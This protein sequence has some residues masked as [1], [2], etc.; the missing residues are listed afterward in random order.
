MNIVNPAAKTLRFIPEIAKRSSPVVLAMACSLSAANAVITVA[1]FDRGDTTAAQVQSTFTGIGVAAPFPAN[2]PAYQG[3]QTAV[4]GT[5][6]LLLA[7][8]TTLAAATTKDGN[9]DFNSIGNLVVR[10]R[11]TPS[12]DSG[13][14]TYSDVYRDFITANFQGIELSGLT[15]DFNYDVTFYAYDNSG[16]RTQTFTD[17]T[18]GS[19]GL[20]GSVTYASGSTF[21]SSTPNNIF[22]T[23][24]NAK[25]DPQGRLF[26]TESGVGTAGSSSVA[27]FNAVVVSVPEPS[28]SIIVIGALGMLGFRRRRCL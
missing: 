25:S 1:S 16:N 18:P 11:G 3:P 15:A 5:V 8:N 7:A 13:T 27:L 4:S 28:S 2:P 6:T 26:F 19:T 12:S 22:A 20:S 14:F 17:V 24:V 23:T 21:N 10:D 9:G